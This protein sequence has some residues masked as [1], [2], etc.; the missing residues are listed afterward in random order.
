MADLIGQMQMKVNDICHAYFSSI[1]RLQN[2]ADQAPLQDVPAQDCRPLATQLAQEVIHSHTEMEEL[3]NTLEG[4]HS[5]E[6]EQLERLRH[7]QAQHD[8]GVMKLRRRTEEAEVIRS[9]MRCDLNDLVQEMRAEDGTAQA[10]LA[11]S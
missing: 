2:E 7:I 4:V 1:G 8:A 6:A 9:R 5:T 10:P 3:I 11:F